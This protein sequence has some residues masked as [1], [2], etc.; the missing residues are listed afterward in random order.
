MRIVAAILAFLFGAAGGYVL[1]IAAY[2][3][4]TELPGVVDRDGAMGMGVAFL[5]GPAV[6][7]LCGVAASVWSLRRSRADQSR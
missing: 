5:I 2:A 1:C 3:G 7:I 6:A 4:Y